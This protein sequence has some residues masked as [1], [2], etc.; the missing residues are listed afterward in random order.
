M[1]HDK[2]KSTLSALGLLVIAVIWGVSFVVMKTAI[3]DAPVLYVLSIRFLLAGV[4]L[5]LIFIKKFFKATKKDYLRGLIL[6]LVLMASYIFQ[7]YGCKYTTASKNSMLTAIYGVLV[8]FVSWIFFKR[9]PRLYSVLFAVLAFIGVGMISLN[10][11]EAVNIGDILTIIGGVF[12]AVQI[13]L[14][15]EYTKESDPV[16]LTMIEFL[17]VGVVLICFAPIEGPFPTFLFTDFSLLWRILFLGFVC[18]MSGFLLQSLLQKR[19]QVVTCGIILSLEAPIGAVTGVLV[20]DD[21]MTT[22]MI[23]GI[24]LLFIAVVGIQVYEP[25]KERIYRKLGK[26]TEAIEIPQDEENSEITIENKTNSEQI[27]VDADNRIEL[28]AKDNNESDSSSPNIEKDDR[29]K[30][31][32]STND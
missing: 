25:V 8:P 30:A 1:E 3:T 6:G 14:L 17:V 23:I 18:T 15:S 32:K 11:F 13:V 12:Y 7:A 20:K 9:K 22:V 19:V 31:D 10:G 16:F 21:P 29:G 27:D 26:S 2:A 5:S 28:E 24:V 4:P